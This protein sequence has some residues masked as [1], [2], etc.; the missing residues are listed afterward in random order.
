MK[1]YLKLSIL[2]LPIIFLLGC[3]ENYQSLRDKIDLAGTWQFQLDPD[4]I[5][6]SEKWYNGGLPDSI[7]LPGTLDENKK[8][9]L[10][11]ERTDY[12]LNRVY[13]HVGSAWFRKEVEIPSSWNEK[14][15]K[16]IMERTKVTSLWIDTTFI[17]SD[18]TIFSKQKYDLS[19][20][21]T[22]GKHVITICVDNSPALVPVEGSHA[23]SED[24]QTNWNGIIGAFCL[25]ASN[26]TRIEEARIYPDVQNKQIRVSV[27]IAKSDLPDSFTDLLLEARSWNS[28]IVH[29]AAP[30][31]YHLENIHSDTTLDIIYKLGSEMLTWSEF[32]PALYK[33]SVTLLEDNDEID[34]REIDFGMREFKNNGTQFSINGITTFLRGKHDACVFPLTGYPPMDVDGWLRVYNIAKTYGINHYRFHTWCPPEAAFQ[35]ADIAG[36]YLQPELP[37]WYSFRAADSSQVEF[38]MKEGKRIMDDYGNHASFV[39]FALGNEIWEDRNTLQKMVSDL[40]EYDDRH[41]FATGSNNRAGNPSYCEGDDFWVSFRTGVEEYD[42]SKDVRG[43]I[44]Y[45]DAIEGGV[46]NTLYPSADKTYI[47]SIE[48]IPVPVIGHEIGQYQTYPDYNEM[49]KYTGILKPTNFKMFRESLKQKGMLDQAESFFKASGALS[50]ILY[51]EDIE[52]ALRTPGFGGFQLL[53]LQDFP[54]QGTALVGILDAFMDSKGLI[55]PEKFKQ[56]C[57]DIVILLDM[58][59]YCWSFDEPFTAKITVANYS[60]ES[61]ESK[62]IHWE[63]Q[64]SENKNILDQGTFTTD[65]ITQGGLKFIGEISSSFN[66]LDKAQK[67]SIHL[68]MEDTK[69]ENEYPLWIYPENIETEIPS[70]IMISNQLDSKTITLLAQGKKVLLFPGAETLKNNSVDGQFITEF[71]NYGMFSSLA[72]RFKRQTPIGTMGLL[73]DIKHPM[74]KNFPTEFHSNWQWWSITK[75]SKPIILDN[76]EKELKPIVQVIDNINRNNKLGLIFEMKVGQGKLL[77]CSSDLKSVIDKPEVKQ[78]FYSILNYIKSESF[79]PEITVPLT[80]LKNLFN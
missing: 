24:T 15:I 80:E 22:P 25:E 26:K 56:F 18:N 14:H 11:T 4:N 33:L 48:G 17:G 67:L 45:L 64:D 31:K 70:D 69:Y 23:Y 77:V 54:G 68:R 12:H 74:L 51:R 47:K 5:G 29:E 3:S 6:I 49:K 50:M 76:F 42:C 79:D 66:S 40:R 43:S 13:Y 62:R 53:D 41:L 78:L 28:K 60:A 61:L 36:I 37:I 72:E 63:I 38:M 19:G 46:L 2:L 27:K 52:I 10:N 75:E 71:W 59:K 30:L 20:Y 9:K 7:L 73:I 21:L 58:K 65:E 34:N 32:N 16:L 1:K 35:A 39:M 8:G 57:N 55:T 44:S